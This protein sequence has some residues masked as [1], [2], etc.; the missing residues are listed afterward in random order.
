MEW[1]QYP[2]MTAVAMETIVTSLEKMGI[3]ES[4]DDVPTAA[5]MAM[6]SIRVIRSI[7]ESSPNGSDRAVLNCLNF[8][9]NT[10]NP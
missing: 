2:F 8:T 3:M 4:G 5:V 10:H 9:R 7:C 1:I 6:C